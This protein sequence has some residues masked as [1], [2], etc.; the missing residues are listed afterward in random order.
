MPVRQSV[1]S[2]KPDPAIFEH[3]VFLAESDGDTTVYIGDNYYTDVLGAQN[4]G[5]LPILYDP[6][7][8]FPDID[9]EK[10]TSIG[11]LLC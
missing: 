7:N 3:A 2:W 1:Y 4:A 6:R 5:I 8:I 9:C 10:I 11:D